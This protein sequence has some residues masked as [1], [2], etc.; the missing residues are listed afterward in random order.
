[1]DGYGFRPTESWT[2]LI[3]SGVALLDRRMAWLARKEEKEGSDL[4]RSV[5]GMAMG[6]LAEGLTGRMRERMR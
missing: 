3:F 5:E 4:R 2:S 1:M 6:R